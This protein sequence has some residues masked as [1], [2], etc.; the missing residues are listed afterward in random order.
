MEQDGKSDICSQINL[1]SS[2]QSQQVEL[3]K[4]ASSLQSEKDREK[5][6]KV[7]EMSKVIQSKLEALQD[8]KCKPHTNINRRMIK[9]NSTW[10]LN[11]IH[12]ELYHSSSESGSS[13]SSHTSD[14][15]TT[16][17]GNAPAVLFTDSPS[18]YHTYNGHSYRVI[19]RVTSLQ[20]QTNSSYIR[21]PSA[22]T[23]LVDVCS[24]EY[25]KN[26]VFVTPNRKQTITTT[27][28]RISFAPEDIVSSDDDDEEIVSVSD[29]HVAVRR[30]ASLF[31][32]E[33]VPSK[34]E[35]P[36]ALEALHPL[37][38]H[39]LLNENKDNLGVT[40]GLLTPP[41]SPQFDINTAEISSEPLILLPHII[42]VQKLNQYTIIKANAIT[43]QNVSG[44]LYKTFNSF[45]GNAVLLLKIVIVSLDS[46]CSE[47]Q[48]RYGFTFWWQNNHTFLQ[49]NDD[50]AKFALA[51][52]SLVR[53][54]LI[55]W[56]ESQNEQFKGALLPSLSESDEIL[57]DG[58]KIYIV[59]NASLFP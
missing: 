35:S 46:Q 44:L 2:I 25:E 3:S 37:D 4:L 15:S 45:N 30:D 59:Y 41:Y 12:P 57:R 5:Y 34:E 52:D 13:R 49:Q 42:H 54:A 19:D 9:K 32:I 18:R 29:I 47:N 26:V 33:K 38:E 27:K 10:S 24:K 28:R 39:A 31:K 20:F 17:C 50:D 51:P 8:V 11:N 7:I 56:T 36:V 43:L 6:I 23:I 55:T 48:R 21:R 14:A 58:R 22:D 16:Y 40:A 53:E 1:M